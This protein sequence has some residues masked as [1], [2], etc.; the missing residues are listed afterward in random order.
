[1]KDHRDNVL[2]EVCIN[3]LMWTIVDIQSR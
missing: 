1:V 2:F 3:Y